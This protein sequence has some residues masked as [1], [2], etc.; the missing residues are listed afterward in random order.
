MTLSTSAARENFIDIARG[1]SI[2]CIILGHFGI[3]SINRVVFTFH[4][5]VFLMI[6]GYFL[7]SR[8]T[9][10]DFIRNKVRTLLVPYF[11]VSLVLLILAAG[12]GF[13]RNNPAEEL[14]TWSAAVLYG[15]G[16]TVTDP[17]FVQGIGAVW[18]LWASFWGSILVRMILEK[19]RWIQILTITAAFLSGYYSHRI[20]QL[21]FSVQQG[22]CASLYIYAGYLLRTYRNRF[23]ESSAFLKHGVL[24]VC[25]TAW[26]FFIHTFRSFWMVQCDFGNGLM[27][28]VQSLCACICV[29][30]ISRLIDLH[31]DRL[32]GTLAWLGR[33][34]LLVLCV[35]SIELSFFP[36]NK[37]LEIIGLHGTVQTV[38][39][40][41][42]KLFIDLTA[43]YLLQKSSFVRSLFHL[44]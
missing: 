15:T 35:H 12:K 14:M 25:F 40:I 27:N 31:S 17:F 41:P 30:L 24:L 10:T 18:F 21:P 20:L 16:D 37:V 34:S 2:L 11:S 9:V 1:I 22:M 5:P 23:N 6:T 28:I 26:F 19:K 29:L 32:A 3:P 38:I 13:L 42:V 39:L 4:V 36:W 8:R 7:S 33:Y 43:V 44:R